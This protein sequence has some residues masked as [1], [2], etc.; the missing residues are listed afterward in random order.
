M[1]Y[2]TLVYKTRTQ[3]KQSNEKLHNWNVKAVFADFSREI[4][5]KLYAKNEVE[6]RVRED[7]QWKPY[8]ED[9]NREIVM[10]RNGCPLRKIGDYRYAF[11]HKSFLEYFVADGVLEII[12]HKN[13]HL[14]TKVLLSPDVMIRD[15]GVVSFM[16][17]AFDLDSKIQIECL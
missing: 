10:A 4:A 1:L 5:L 17:D 14:Q 8:F 11:I 3:A 12:T 2:G 15:Q 6:I 7:P 16:R 9:H 13:I